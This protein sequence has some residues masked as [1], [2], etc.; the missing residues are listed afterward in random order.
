MTWCSAPH[1]RR[2]HHSDKLLANKG[3]NCRALGSQGP[4]AISIAL[5]PLQRGHPNIQ[6]F[7]GLSNPS[8]MLGY[9]ESKVI[10]LPELPLA[11]PSSRA[12]RSPNNLHAS[13]MGPSNWA[14]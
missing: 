3:K 2:H 11:I 10:T 8:W 1:P 7:L 13:L 4:L 9:A 14:R 12:S 6:S 5:N